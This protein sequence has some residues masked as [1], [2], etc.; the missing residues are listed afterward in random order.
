MYVLKRNLMGIGMPEEIME[1]C[2]QSWYF[3]GKTAFIYDLHAGV[4]D[5]NPA[6]ARM[7]QR[8]GVCQCG[9][10]IF[11]GFDQ[12]FRTCRPNSWIAG[13]MWNYIYS[14]DCCVGLLL[15]WTTAKWHLPRSNLSNPECWAMCAIGH[16]LTILRELWWWRHH[17][18]N[19]WS[20]AA[21]FLTGG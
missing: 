6:K 2:L 13:R 15:I 19:S 5:P 16:S 20:D 12:Y 3:S 10:A 17:D 1:M 18:G 7:T 8:A 4:V 14:L 11:T 21:I 9:N